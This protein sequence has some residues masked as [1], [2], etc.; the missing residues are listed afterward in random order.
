[1]GLRS[2]IGWYIGPYLNH[3]R[4]VRVYIPEAKSERITDNIT[5]ITEDSISTDLSPHESIIQSTKYLTQEIQ[6]YLKG[7]EMGPYHSKI[8]S[9]GKLKE[10]L[11]S[12]TEHSK[13]EHHIKNEDHTT[14]QRVK[15]KTNL[16]LHQHMI[17]L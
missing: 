2:I 8:E 1:M 7:K 6:K 10:L 16:T 13:G 17:I 9:L 14:I 15:I 5:I 4:C 11:P 12:L 3:Y